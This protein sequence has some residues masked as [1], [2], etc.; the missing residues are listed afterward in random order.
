MAIEV[1]YFNLNCQDCNAAAQKYRGCNG[2]PTHPY[3][4][5]GEPLDR[6]PV[7]LISPISTWILNSYWFFKQGF[8]P[9]TGTHLDQPV[10]LTEAWKIIS[11]KETE[12]TNRKR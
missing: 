1:A 7:K 10:K 4:F 3:I 8:L 9:F 6:C 5:E 2:E 12:L 11:N